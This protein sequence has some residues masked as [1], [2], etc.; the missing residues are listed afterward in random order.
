MFYTVYKITNNVNGKIYIGKH[1][2]KNLEDG[3]M[4][5]GKL[6]R[7]AIK[8][9]GIENFV[10]EY[11][12]VYDNELDMNNKEAEIVTESFCLLTDNYNLCR[13]GAGGFS[14]VNRSGL[15]KGTEITMNIPKYKKVFLEGLSKGRETQKRLW[16]ENIEWSNKERLAR[17]VITKKQNKLNGNP[18]KGKFHTDDTKKKIGMANAVAQSGSRNSQFGMMWITNG[19]ENKKIKNDAAI[20]NG[21]KKGRVCK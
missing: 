4:G 20:P 19:T 9:Y 15:R 1:Q 12:F 11:L 7:Q 6:I 3:Y 13:G 8:K 17:S 18:F 2:T 21:W 14:Y 5:S 16:K 10:K